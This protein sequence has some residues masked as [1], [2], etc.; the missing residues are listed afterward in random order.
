VDI[1]A[2]FEEYTN[3]EK[4]TFRSVIDEGN[5]LLLE[6]LKFNKKG[7]FEEYQDVFL[8]IQLWLYCKFGINQ[9]LWSLSKDSTNKFI[10]RK[11]VW[12]Q[13]YKYVGLKE[14][15]SNYCGNYNKIEK[16][17]KQLSIFGISKQ[18]AQKAYEKVVSEPQ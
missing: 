12:K 13:I 1:K 10:K 5:E 4:V 2:F 11:A 7:V 16:V 14:D 15:I 8:F 6:I 3:N 9:K 18:K 17:I